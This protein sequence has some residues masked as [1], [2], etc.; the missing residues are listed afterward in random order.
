MN[1]LDYVQ[2]A[3]DFIEDNLQEDIELEGIAREAALSVPHLYRMFYSLTGHPIKD[4]LRK[5]RISIAAE[6]LKNS[7]LT[8][9]DIALSSG[10]ESQASFSKS[11]KKI[12]GVSPKVYKESD[13]HYFYERINLYEK[14]NYLESRE[15]FER[16][17]DVKVI[18]LKNMMVLSYIHKSGSAEGIEMEAFT[19][20]QALLHRN[21]INTK[22]IRF[23]GRNVEADNQ[24]SFEH[25]RDHFRY[26]ILVHV[27]EVNNLSIK[28][29]E[30]KEIAAGL[31]AVGATQVD[32][33]QKII[34]LWNTLL[35]EWLPKSSFIE[36]SHTYLEEYITYHDKLVRMK[37]YLPIERKANPEV[38]KVEEVEPFWVAYSRCYGADSQEKADITLSKWLQTESHFIDHSN[39]NLYVSYDFGNE[40]EVA[41]WSEYGISFS[42]QNE[43]STDSNIQQKILGGGLF[44]V[45]ETKA[46]GTLTGVLEIIHRWIV[47]ENK[48]VLDSTRQW[49]AMYYPST[50]TNDI[51]VKCYIPIM[52]RSM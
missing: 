38:M 39:N 9:L 1:Y 44:A 35:S 5:R 25:N 19:S 22:N 34:G 46:Y 20:A 21:K 33:E 16:Y 43:R 24:R 37:L 30:V 52:E 11:F 15:L 17:P 36:G 4:Y 23:F 45:M 7:N 27:D 18:Q 29:M 51:T 47:A 40:K 28:N 3:I 2:R 50:I 26:E 32:K 41:H 12:V 6:H 13:V 42:K 8:V 48:Y 31:Y 10:F 14:V 49:F